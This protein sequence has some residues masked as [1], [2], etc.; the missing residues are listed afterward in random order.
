M[1]SLWDL[2]YGQTRFIR[3]IKAQGAEL[4]FLLELGLIPNTRVQVG[5]TA[6]LEGA[7]VYRIDERQLALCKELAQKVV[8]S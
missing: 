2:R 6:P 8:V 3:E 4:D 7:V 5:H 1:K